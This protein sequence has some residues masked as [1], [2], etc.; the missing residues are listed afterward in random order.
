MNYEIRHSTIA[1]EDLEYIVG[2]DLDGLESIIPADDTN[3]DYQAYLVSLE[4]TAV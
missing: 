4:E 2:V 1:G 3:A